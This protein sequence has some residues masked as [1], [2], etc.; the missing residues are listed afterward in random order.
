MKFFFPAILI[1]AIGVSASS[2]QTN[3]NTNAVNEILALVTT[4]AP[5][6]SKP[7]RGPTRIES[8]SAAFDLNGHSATY[9]GHVRVDD[10]QMKLR[11]EWL[12]ASLPQGGGRVTNIVAE[13]NVVIDFT[14]DKGK[15]NQAT[16]DKAVY[17]YNVQ[18]DVTNETVTL[19]GN[20]KIENAQGWLTGDP[21]VWNRA[22]N[23]VTAKNEKMIFRQNLNGSSETNSPQTIQNMGTNSDNPSP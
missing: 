21:I 22:N 12:F 17:F 8:D 2:A 1:F 19:T 10:P 13:R 20:A 4:N 5:A 9:R 23:S 7:A 15:T 3:A 14:D 18:N 11:C 6:K 16:G